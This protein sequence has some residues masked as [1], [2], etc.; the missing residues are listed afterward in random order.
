M[1][2]ERGPSGFG[3]PVGSEDGTYVIDPINVM[4]VINT[5]NLTAIYV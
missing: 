3:R 4:N 5:K 1:E 2:E